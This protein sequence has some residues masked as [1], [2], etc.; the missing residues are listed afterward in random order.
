MHKFQGRILSCYRNG[1]LRRRGIYN[2]G[3]L[4]AEELFPYNDFLNERRGIIPDGVVVYRDKQGRITEISHY[5]NNK[6]NGKSIYYDKGWLYSIVSW[7]DDIKH[8]PMVYYD[9]K[10]FKYAWKTKKHGQLHGKY[11]W[12]VGNY[13]VVRTYNNGK[14]IGKVRVFHKNGKEFL[15]NHDLSFG[16]I[17]QIL[18]VI[19][20]EVRKAE[21]RLC[22]SNE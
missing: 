16:V 18:V 6:L 15:I 8:G 5:K 3:K 20:Q 21:L 4:L 13:T 9:R 12:R 11:Y 22:R 1:S 2:N 14:R 17:L 10:G 19:K 7:K